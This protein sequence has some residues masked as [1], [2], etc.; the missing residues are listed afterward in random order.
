MAKKRYLVNFKLDVINDNILDIMYFVKESMCDESN[1]ILSICDDARQEARNVM[2]NP[3]VRE[4][5]LC[6]KIYKIRDILDKWD[7]APDKL[8][9]RVD[10]VLN[11]LCD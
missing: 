3:K 7:D 10:K 4:Q 1:E 9:Q 5:L 11:D 8:V 2:R 6:G